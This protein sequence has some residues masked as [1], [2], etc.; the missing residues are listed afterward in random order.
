MRRAAA[1]QRGGTLSVCMIVRNE[2]AIL[3]KALVSVRDV[4]QE[5]V[6]VDTGSSDTTIEVARAHG[7]RVLEIAWQDD[8][9]AARNA[10]LAA[11]TGDWILCLDA[12]EE[13]AGGQEQA[14]RQCLRRGD[15]GAWQVSLHSA[16]AGA[17]AGQ[18]FVHRY[19]RLFRNIKGVRF[20]G[21]VHEQVAPSLAATGCV[22]RTSGLV[23]VHSGYC[24][25]TA[26]KQSKLER[27]LRLLE[28]DRADRPDDGFV[29][30]HLGE[31]RALLQQP[32]EAVPCY[33]AALRTSTLDTA[34]RAAAY[35]NLASVLLRL[36]RLDEAVAAADAALR[37]D[38][39]TA[40]ALL[41]RA[42]ARTRQG[43]FEA[44]R[45]D[46]DAYL[47]QCARGKAT[48]VSLGFAPD[49]PRAWL[50]VAECHMRAGNWDA[51]EHAAAEV[52]AA[53]TDWAPCERILAQL[54]ARRGARDEALA[55]WWRAARLE[56]SLAG[57]WCELVCALAEQDVEA[58]LAAT[59]EALQQTRDTQLFLLQ[60]RLR[61]G[62]NQLAAAA[63]S[64][65][66]VLRLDAT[67]AEAH[68]RLA[69]LYHKLG[70]D[71]Q[72]LAHL[73]QMHAL[74]EAV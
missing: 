45:H 6:V 30:Y 73:Q 16:L 26:H 66:T 21:R 44:A 41:V 54:A 51:A 37:T 65:E 2:A 67:C 52:R 63:E 69:G 33:E 10:A 56:P 15:T 35:Q 3:S 25:G 36:G 60:A 72:A 55:H 12:D 59:D 47:R 23:L 13:L 20:Q 50:I 24:I 22:V 58:A 9:A 64:Y 53:R 8:F 34:H 71:G 19:P 17:Q 57:G 1:V 31:T 74:A 4:A 32:A 61:I 70:D 27:N 48:G 62:M 39:Q 18:E 46:A 29:L 49:A 7:A 5:I 38:S 42:A 11:A 28:L 68:R 14:L 43:A 40:M